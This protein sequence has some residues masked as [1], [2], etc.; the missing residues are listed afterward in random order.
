MATADILTA[1]ASLHSATARAAEITI[2][3]NDAQIIRQT[4]TLMERL[5]RDL[6][7]NTPEDNAAYSE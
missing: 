4:I 5:T 6:N 2:K 1:S 7:K 3:T